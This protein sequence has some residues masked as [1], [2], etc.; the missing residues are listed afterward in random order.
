MS[1]IP[2]YSTFIGPF[3]SFPKMPVTS[4]CHLGQLTQLGSAQLIQLGKLLRGIYQQTLFPS[5]N[6][7]K[8][9][10]YSTRYRRTLQSLISFLYGFLGSKYIVPNVNLRES[11]SITFCFKDCSCKLVERLK[12]LATKSVQT[13]PAG[14]LLQTN[15]NR[16]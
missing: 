14:K 13:T 15:H 4:S 7:F 6:Q 1:K 3:H 12:K 5:N 8:I 10:S 2:G 9:I 11:Q 16:K